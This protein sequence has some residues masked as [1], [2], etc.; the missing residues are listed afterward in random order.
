MDVNIETVLNLASVFRY[1][2][3]QALGTILQH[4]EA[5][6]QLPGVQLVTVQRL[7]DS[8]TS[9]ETNTIQLL[10]EVQNIF[11][12]QTALTAEQEVS[13]LLNLLSRSSCLTFQRNKIIDILQTYS[14]GSMLKGLQESLRK[15]EPS[16]LAHIVNL[17]KET[18]LD[19][20]FKK[21][22]HG[23]I[24]LT[25]S[26]LV[27][28]LNNIHLQCLLPETHEV[29]HSVTGE[30]LHKQNTLN[31]LLPRIIVKD[32]ENLSN[33]LL[34]VLSF[35]GSEQSPLKFSVK[36]QIYKIIPFFIPEVC[37]NVNPQLVA[38]SHK[39]YKLFL[40][41]KDDE[42]PCDVV[43]ARDTLA[44][45]ISSSKLDL[46]KYS[47]GFAPTFYG[48]DRLSVLFAFLAR[49]SFSL[50]NAHPVSAYV[51]T[52]LSYV[53]MKYIASNGGTFIPMVQLDIAMLLN[54]FNT[55]GIDLSETNAQ[56]YH[57]FQE[58]IQWK[59][60][61][62][63]FPF[64]RYSQP[65]PLFIAM[66]HRI[67]G[68]NEEIKLCYKIIL[69]YFLE[70]VQ[71]PIHQCQNFQISEL[72]TEV[73][74]FVN[75]TTLKV[76]ILP[77]P[78]NVLS[79]KLPAVDVKLSTEPLISIIKDKKFTTITTPMTD[80]INNV[81]NN[82]VP[83]SLYVDSSTDIS[84]KDLSQMKTT[85]RT[86]STAPYNILQM[87]HTLAVPKPQSSN[88]KYHED[89]I[90][91]TCP[92]HQIK[93]SIYNITDLLEVIDKNVSNDH[94]SVLNNFL[95]GKDI[96]KLLQAFSSE[97]RKTKAD[98]LT[99]LITSVKLTYPILE[100]NLNTAL[101]NILN[102][103]HFDGIG[104]LKPNFMW[105]CQDLDEKATT[106]STQT[107]ILKDII[108][109]SESYSVTQNAIK[110]TTHK[111]D[112]SEITSLE[113][114]ASIDVTAQTTEQ[115]TSSTNGTTGH[116]A[117]PPDGTT[118]YT[119]NETTQHYTLAT[120][121]TTQQHTLPTL[122]QLMYK[123]NVTNTTLHCADQYTAVFIPNIR[124]LLQAVSQRVS[125]KSLHLVIT[126]FERKD[127][128]QILK[129]F[130]IEDLKSRAE[131]L[132]NMLTFVKHTHVNLAASILD[133]FNEVLSHVQFKDIGVSKHDF[134]LVCEDI[135]TLQVNTL[136]PEN[137]SVNATSK[138]T[139]IHTPSLL[140]I[141]TDHTRNEKE[142]LQ[143]TEK[144]VTSTLFPMIASE[145]FPS[146]KTQ[147]YFTQTLPEKI[148]Q[149]ES[150][151]TDPPS[152]TTTHY[153][154]TIIPESTT[155]EQTTSPLSTEIIESVDLPQL[156]ILSNLSR[157]IEREIR[158][159][160]CSSQQ[161]AAKIPNIQSL[162]NAVANNVSIQNITF[163]INFF[164]RQNILHILKEFNYQ[165]NAT[166]ADMLSNV[167]TFVNQT[168]EN[169][170]SDVNSIFKTILSHIIFDGQLVTQNDYT[171][172]C[173]DIT[174][175][176][177]NVPPLQPIPAEET[178]TAY[179][180]PTDNIR[181]TITHASESS[182]LST[183]DPAD[184]TTTTSS[185][186]ILIPIACADEY[187]GTQI[188]SYNI[189]TLLDSLDSSTP[190]RE[191]NIVITYLTQPGT[192]NILAG[193]TDSHPNNHNNK[194]TAFSAGTFTTYGSLFKGILLFL[195]NRAHVPHHVLTATDVI[196]PHVQTGGQGVLQLHAAT[197]C[198]PSSLHAGAEPTTHLGRLR[199]ANKTQTTYTPNTF[200][201]ENPLEITH[202]TQ[203]TTEPTATE[204]LSTDSITPLAHLTTEEFKFTIPTVSSTNII[205][206]ITS[207]VIHCTDEQ[208]AVNIPNIKTLLK[209][210]KGTVSKH[211][212]SIVIN[213][214]ERQNTLHIL[215]RFNA[216]QFIT[217]GD[218]LR[219]MITFVKVTYRHLH[220]S[221]LDAFNDILSNIQDD[222]SGLL[223]PDFI[224][225]CLDTTVPQHIS[226]PETTTLKYTPEQEI[227]E[228]TEIKTHETE[229]TNSE[230]PAPV[231]TAPM[232]EVSA[233]GVATMIHNLRTEKMGSHTLPNLHNI[234]VSEE[235]KHGIILC[236]EQKTV[237]IPN[238]TSLLKAI[239]TAVSQEHL[240]TVLSFFSRKDIVHILQGFNAED[241][242]TRQELLTKIIRFVKHKYSELTDS[243]LYAFNEILSHIRSDGE[244]TVKPDFINVCEDSDIIPGSNT[245]ATVSTEGELLKTTNDSDIIRTTVV[246][247]G[248]SMPFKQTLKTS[249][250]ANKTDTHME[251]IIPPLHTFADLTTP[252]YT[253]TINA[254]LP[255]K[256]ISQAIAASTDTT[257]TNEMVESTAMTTETTIPYIL[258]STLPN[259]LKDVLDL[260]SETYQN[261]VANNVTKTV[262]S[263]TFNVRNITGDDNNDAKISI[264]LPGEE[265]SM[266][267]KMAEEACVEGSTQIRVTDMTSLLQ[268]LDSSV[269]EKL[270][271][272]TIIQTVGTSKIQNERR[273]F[274]W[275][276]Y[277]SKE[278]FLKD[279]LLYLISNS[280]KTHFYPSIANFKFDE[281]KTR[282][283]QLQELLAYVI[284]EGNLEPAILDAAETLLQHVQLAGPGALPPDTKI[285]CRSPL[286]VPTIMPSDPTVLSTLDDDTNNG[287]I[288]IPTQCSSKQ[289]LTGI[290]MV[291]L[292]SLFT[293]IDSSAPSDLVSV[294]MNALSFPD[295]RQTLKDYNWD[296][297]ET[298]AQLLKDLIT[299]VAVKT[300]QNSEVHSAAQ[301]LLPYVLTSGAGNYPPIMKF[302]CDTDNATVITD[303]NETLVPNYCDE[304][305]FSKKIT[306]LQ[307]LHISSLFKALKPVTPR[308][309][310]KVV[311]SLF[312]R[313]DFY[314]K[315][316]GFKLE[317]YKTKG[318]L[319]QELLAYLMVGNSMD[320]KM[321][322]AISTLI[323]YVQLDG[324][325]AEIVNS[326]I[327]CNVS[328]PRKLS[329]V[330]YE[331]YERSEEPENDEIEITN[332]CFENG[333][334]QILTVD[335]SPL[336][337]IID[338][339]SMTLLQIKDILRK[340]SIQ[341]KLKTFNWDAY[342]ETKGKLLKDI[343]DFLV[344]TVAYK[345]Q[346]YSFL[347]TVT[348]FVN[349]DH[350]GAKPPSF[351]FSCIT[352]EQTQSDTIE[353]GIK[354]EDITGGPAIVKPAH[355]QCN[356]MSTPILVVNIRT[357]FTALKPTTPHL[358]KAI[359]TAYVTKPH[360]HRKI[361]NL[362]LANFKTRGEQLQELLAYL[363]TEASV[364]AKVMKAIN[365]LL[366]NV[367]LD[368]PGKLPSSVKIV[369]NTTLNKLTAI[370]LP[371]EKD[372]MTL[373]P[374]IKQTQPTSVL[375][376]CIQSLSGTTYQIDFRTIFYALKRNAPWTSIA[377]IVSFLTKPDVYTLLKNFDVAVHKTRGNLLASLLLFLAKKLDHQQDMIQ[378]IREILPY[379]QYDGLG[380]KSP[381]VVPS[382]TLSDAK[383][384]I[385]DKS[386]P[387]VEPS[388]LSQGPKLIDLDGNECM[389]LSLGSSH[390]KGRTAYKV[391]VPSLTKLLN[392]TSVEPEAMAKLFVSEHL[393]NYFHVLNF[394]KYSSRAE[395][396]RGML[397]IL[398]N[399]S[400]PDNNNLLLVKK[401]KSHIQSEGE[402][403]LPPLISALCTEGLVES[404][405][406][407][408]MYETNET[409]F[410]PSEYSTR[411]MSY[412]LQ[413][414][415]LLQTIKPEAPKKMANSVISF[416]KHVNV[417][418]YLQNFNIFWYKTQG[419][420][421]KNLLLF[422][423][424]KPEIKAEYKEA[425]LSIVP[426]I[427]MDG[428]GALT[429][430]IITACPESQNN[431]EVT[432]KTPAT[433]VD[434]TK[435]NISIPDKVTQDSCT[436]NPNAI[437]TS[438]FD[439]SLFQALDISSPNTS[440]AII[441]DYISGKD[442]MHTKLHK[443]DVKRYATKGD[444]LQALLAFI[445]ANQDSQENIKEAARTL[446]PHVIFNGQGQ[447]PQNLKTHCYMPKGS[448]EPT[449][450]SDSLHRPTLVYPSDKT[451][452][453]NITHIPGI[454]VYR[455][456]IP[457][458]F[459]ALKPRIQRELYL[460]VAAFLSKPYAYKYIQG[461]N[462]ER[463]NTQGELL[464]A[465]LTV[466]RFTQR[467]LGNKV[468][469][470]LN[471]LL[472]SVH[473]YGTHK[474][475]IEKQT[476]CSALLT[477]DRLHTIDLNELM[478]TI[479]KHKL[480][481][482]ASD[483]LDA[484]TQF[485]T[486]STFNL[487]EY[488][489][490]LDSEQPVTQGELLKLILLQIVDKNPS[491][492]QHAAILL[493]HIRE[494]KGVG[495]KV[496]KTGTM[497]KAKT[498][499]TYETDFLQ[500]LQ[501]LKAEAPKKAVAAIFNLFGK[502]DM[503]K[504]LEGFNPDSYQTQGELLTGILTHLRVK[505]DENTELGKIIL[506]LIPFVDHDNAGA[507]PP[508]IKKIYVT[509]NTSANVFT[510]DLGTLYKV[511]PRNNLTKDGKQ[512]LDTIF[513]YLSRNETDYLE[514]LQ[515]ISSQLPPK[516]Q[517]KLILNRLKE[518]GDS[519]LEFYIDIILVYLE[520]QLAHDSY[521]DSEHIPEMDW[522]EI[523][524]AIPDAGVP[525]EVIAGKKELYRFLLSETF[526]NA[527]HNFR[528]S[529]SLNRAK[530]LKVLLAYLRTKSEV[531]R[532]EVIKNA[533]AYVYMF[534]KDQAA[535]LMPVHDDIILP[536]QQEEARN[537]QSH[538]KELLYQVLDL[539]QQEGASEI[540]QTLQSLF[541]STKL[542]L[543]TTYLGYNILEELIPKD[544][545]IIIL[546][547]I[548]H[549][550]ILFLDQDTISAI[551][552]VFISLGETKEQ[553][554]QPFH[555]LP[556]SM[557]ELLKT[558]LGPDI[559]PSVADAAETIRSHVNLKTVPLGKAFQDTVPAILNLNP[560]NRLAVVLRIL[561]RT[562]SKR[563]DKK[564]L[565]VIKTVY[566]HIHPQKR[567]TEIQ[568]Q[569][570]HMAI[571]T[572]LT[573]LVQTNAP[574]S[575]Q[576]A[577]QIVIDH[578]VVQQN[579][580]DKALAS[581]VTKNLSSKELVARA[582][583]RFR[584]HQHKM[585]PQLWLSVSTILE[586]LHVSEHDST[587]D[588]TDESIN[589]V[590]EFKYL[591][592][593]AG[594][595]VAPAKRILMKF[596][597]NKKQEISK[598]FRGRRVL[599]QLAPREKMVILLQRLLRIYRETLEP[600]IINAVEN[601]LNQLNASLP[602]EEDEGKID[603][604]QLLDAVIDQASPDHVI[605]AKNLIKTTLKE[606]PSMI[607]H[608]LNGIVIQEDFNQHRRLT[609]ILRRIYRK[610]K[611]E[612][613]KEMAQSLITLFD[614]LEVPHDTSAEDQFAGNVTFEPLFHEVFPKEEI[615]DEVEEALRIVL[616]LFSSEQVNFKQML[617]GVHLWKL[618]TETQV[619]LILY[620]LTKNVDL[621]QVG[622]AAVNTLLESLDADIN[623]LATEDID[624]SYTPE[625]LFNEAL[626]NMHIPAEIHEAK[627]I[628]MHFLL[629]GSSKVKDVYRGTNFSTITSAKERLVTILKNL[630]IEQEILGAK[631]TEALR[632]MSSFLHVNFADWK[633][634]PY[635]FDFGGVFD[636]AVPSIAP[637]TV[638]RA[639]NL[640]LR[641]IKK[642]PGTFKR[643][644]NHITVEE[645]ENYIKIVNKILNA[646]AG[647]KHHLSFRIRMA[648][649]LLI[650]FLRRVPID[651]KHQPM[652]NENED[653]DEY[654]AGSNTVGLRMYEDKTQSKSNK[655]KWKKKRKTWQ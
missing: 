153:T 321:I 114:I 597:I 39:Y 302:E 422:L 161:I 481:T 54:S 626:G 187:Q 617:H 323:Q 253:E 570:H 166:K 364:D 132:T 480:S 518:V 15:I 454:T 370:P 14:T 46:T 383:Q 509:T 611:L 351:T 75:P 608:I 186:K 324:P 554:S 143:A 645:Y 99:K 87:S 138:N 254:I 382:C 77:Q 67:L 330:P 431:K 307:T 181:S 131:L 396:L 125:V 78:V 6:E 605:T 230:A 293:A 572:A 515:S 172:I 532:I 472:Y 107:I 499:L 498:S 603:I 238:I 305:I 373:P 628:I 381:N 391:D 142:I 94:I 363:V 37:K 216:N 368:G 214:F 471:K 113:K 76:P 152:T 56:I 294:V 261:L 474:L 174:L 567:E 4:Q 621:N 137:A 495:K 134:I 546:R 72:K 69:K 539:T 486:S 171:E 535:G 552:M 3:A 651:D 58:E 298:R 540:L 158:K 275:D 595:A 290:L 606:N 284:A 79:E 116:Y 588:E 610:F 586:Y 489:P 503:Y 278:E 379:I 493:P 325:G 575:V 103:I 467:E 420:M 45:A 581:L 223:K 106:P 312:S 195:K 28:L 211:S 558:V 566:E 440:V 27:G 607:P 291:D 192:Y 154:D 514:L 12:S 348:P 9:R 366:Q 271:Q 64:Y 553:A 599:L 427:H 126:F 594:I 48:N 646:T 88:L 551:D 115:Y 225:V 620:R 643:I 1:S 534:I 119:A 202:Y 258:G 42:L 92:D 591:I 460:P 654:E 334:M 414:E 296:D 569:E 482:E 438:K 593:E 265:T 210:V 378:A 250:T 21:I 402:G 648:T 295:I 519:S 53:K 268:A 512:A 496:V 478:K 197:T 141:K 93:I 623:E 561:W 235:E 224:T 652:L 457:S 70:K 227:V 310:K 269:S 510:L 57:A 74:P 241:F 22:Q 259:T 176:T 550:Y 574:S 349:M 155:T 221:I 306:P 468:K 419:E 596:M 188:T 502:Q 354:L 403:T 361:S 196:L 23:Y 465:V 160:N 208:R 8:L 319:L 313:L 410:M 86:Q 62:R 7:H 439:A 256:L 128:V 531:T 207:Y 446:L 476:E 342:H 95:Q 189:A 614:H 101:D 159:L 201:P 549:N 542:H 297:Y 133:A 118:E 377:K 55:L 91:A 609:V 469:E 362:S 464:R 408:I 335:V 573:S 234:Q 71:N 34:K 393:Q 20:I 494:G 218:L 190:I 492:R 120:D 522:I 135:S 122:A 384:L 96:V 121:I 638:Q 456:D 459:K 340:P 83:Q 500:L 5:E 452:I 538:I 280:T 437:I 289:T 511:I 634:D 655:K 287:I 209:A 523:L 148:T 157:H 233:T 501:V 374:T 247:K 584:E 637:Q 170:N 405:P 318:E 162:L 541:D 399:Y 341:E 281:F 282:G 320:H 90:T 279:I 527:V 85:S 344:N 245:A 587:E 140:N 507:V 479:T 506:Q 536:G 17:D 169:L 47:D 35:L 242:N 449:A 123:E 356:N 97:Q 105:V 432:V 220:P 375:A 165:E 448:P 485:T 604:F 618:P 89:N 40:A 102:N 345:Q 615:P 299:F 484:I 357:L 589:V 283:E 429:S 642:R 409:C 149:S 191:K 178:K 194:D 322:G 59:R 400:H 226:L 571:I 555:F 639:K 537:A 387:T 601:I 243:D 31:G 183:T 346:E 182:L 416:F 441:S 576:D 413:T 315:I 272:T 367:R 198:N 563:H 10:L 129:G 582:L 311:S 447:Q 110:Q 564:L 423:A 360:F 339:P 389:P 205:Q 30:L 175:Q 262:H 649:D 277:H 529:L 520:E 369:C 487:T 264:M 237:S 475:P 548:Y 430:V 343:I 444:L 547:R 274:D 442:V 273:V 111:N 359:V 390:V 530:F 32:Q 528:I 267:E 508:I 236:T 51:H 338:R 641:A 231:S 568:T 624:E 585:E 435:G 117:L 50:P 388:P 43:S 41:I 392:D 625:K 350:K 308:R 44:S 139:E 288:I 443:F 219:K 543:E 433:S 314:K 2:M 255:I 285:I 613:S 248:P 73:H 168:G 424:M 60:I 331:F 365:K 24:T 372:V 630:Y 326:N 633:I 592:D 163:V 644:L 490:W 526:K 450:G 65:R 579:V 327:T 458:L 13:M 215:K 66:L 228:T 421:M 173:Q 184:F 562:Y 150:T 376:P 329:K 636:R 612:L 622:K 353:K 434:E 453:T 516:I 407:Y 147:T 49:L 619:S 386:Y 598:I 199:S 385:L 497:K 580:Y 80:L 81:H 246:D 616:E 232:T 82:T 352:K 337:H 627:G 286:N 127:V 213:F 559:P 316:Q 436:S 590:D 263:D 203:S 11:Q 52:L 578:L 394:K 355:G 398:E 491:I 29:L 418:M 244:E 217:S 455:I 417:H 18:F 124:N 404:N 193:L 483:S 451:C 347:N 470:A 304:G 38:I 425:M 25:T 100:K 462:M 33:F 463:Y 145:D 426:Y 521:Q 112:I 411:G 428:P 461:I 206:T 104:H 406:Q 533:I 239:D 640:L 36:L 477:K 513:K 212:L 156:Q 557:E 415:T 109:H 180:A 146:T 632:V 249:I 19:S 583:R 200:I 517:L 252:I 629:S 525:A 466:L 412:E 68:S 371:E 602:M 328:V 292:P 397:S 544:R 650:K 631:M 266:T 332:K 84:L 257:D 560:S 380:S 545:L 395:L 144:K 185:S 260:H 164:Q 647:Y 270:K 309:H 504:N 317:D 240:H 556:I 600:E 98:I 301:K 445:W 179:S 401:I 108:Q 565:E 136:P 473:M 63:N 26:L 577:K 653:S 16:D 222:V 151:D 276:K 336:V 635:T 358:P 229:F 61:L 130:Y 333:T 251:E 303:S 505:Y 524:H 300:S 204:Q 177:M 488:L 167:I